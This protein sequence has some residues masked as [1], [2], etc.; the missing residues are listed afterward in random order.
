MRR[1]DT[2][3]RAASSTVTAP[4]PA[5]SVSTALA[6]GS[7]SA[8]NV[9]S[10]LWVN[11]SGS[12]RF[13]I[14]AQ[15]SGAS[16]SA[17]S[18]A[19]SSMVSATGISSGVVTMFTAVTAGSAIR[20]ATQRV[21]SRSGPTS[22]SSWIASAAPSWATMWPVAAA[23][24]I[25]MSCSARPSIDSRVSH[26]I[27]PIVRI[28]LTPGAAVATKSSAR[29]SGPRRP[30]IGTRMLSFRYSRSDASVSIAMARTPG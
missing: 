8:S 29:A 20:S 23:S 4:G 24:T 15:P 9:S 2:A 30:R 22:M 5:R 19:T 13:T 18:R 16:T 26:A 27:L 1:N 11:S 10:S 17:R 7:R 6:S 28:S 14:T 3:S 21:C 12:T 25:T